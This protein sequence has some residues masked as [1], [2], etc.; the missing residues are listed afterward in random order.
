[1]PPIK[2]ATAISPPNHFFLRLDIRFPS[3]LALTRALDDPKEED[4]FENAERAIADSEAGEARRHEPEQHTDEECAGRQEPSD[5]QEPGIG[6]VAIRVVGCRNV[7]QTEDHQQ[8][9]VVIEPY[10]RLKRSEFE[11]RHQ[12]VRVD[13][14]SPDSERKVGDDPQPYDDGEQFAFNRHEPLPVIAATPQQA[15]C[16][17]RYSIKAFF[18]FSGSSTP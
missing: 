16:V 8:D 1:M 2:A 9:R 17:F 3:T 12:A 18:S 15:H 6:A 14:D 4:K 7:E 13:E 10:S 11:E 5:N